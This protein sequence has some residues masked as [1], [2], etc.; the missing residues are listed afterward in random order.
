MRLVVID[1]LNMLLGGIAGGLLGSAGSSDGRLARDRRLRDGL[2]VGD[3]LSSSPVAAESRN[4]LGLASSEC[5]LLAD[6][7]RFT[8]FA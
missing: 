6:R 1:T 4:L 3:C 8:P 2:T 5:R 7:E